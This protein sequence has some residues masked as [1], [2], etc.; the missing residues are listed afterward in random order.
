[1]N[2]Q[3]LRNLVGD[4]NTNWK[5]VT[6]VVTIG[7]VAISGIL[8][9]QNFWPARQEIS[10]SG[11]SKEEVLR[12]TE[13]VLR[14]IKEK[15]FK[16]VLPYFIYGDTKQTA[17]AT[18]EDILV[19]LALIEETHKENKVFD[20]SISLENIEIVGDEGQALVEFNIN[21]QH[22]TIRFDFQNI[23]ESWKIKVITF[24]GELNLIKTKSEEALV[25][26]K[27]EKATYS[28]SPGTFSLSNND[29]LE[30]EKTLIPS[31]RDG[32]KFKMRNPKDSY[33]VAL[34]EAPYIRSYLEVRAGALFSGF[35]ALD[36][37]GLK[38]SE[39]IILVY[40]GATKIELK[41]SEI[42]SVPLLQ[43]PI[44]IQNK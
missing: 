44:K 26:K 30:T 43:I 41:K 37:S 1:M 31:K 10:R 25:D 35:Y 13:M 7:L 14:G 11:N 16:E 29:L 8:V 39:G 34:Y 2:N 19:A 5:Y 32:F 18:E 28:V 4:P 40:P 27:F 22:A 17:K 12:I 15:K 23:N 33:V 24:G 36:L 9:C 42:S 3:K 38:G 21:G 6:V 20:Y